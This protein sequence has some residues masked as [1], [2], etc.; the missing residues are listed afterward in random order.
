[1]PLSNPPKSALIV[2]ASGGIG[3]SIAQ[4]LLQDPRVQQVHAT[5]RDAT[6]LASQL[7][8]DQNTG[9][10]LTCHDLDIT[11]AQSIEQV[12]TRLSEQAIE[13]DWIICATGILHDKTGDNP[14]VPE[15]R[16]ADVEPQT[17]MDNF[18]V[19][20]IGPLL[21]AKH[22]SSLLPRT[23][24]A[25]FSALSARVGSIG[26]NRLGGW[27]SYRASKAALNMLV[28]NLSIELVRR[29]RG[30]I[31]TALHP[32]TVDTGLSRPFQAKVAAGKLFDPTRAALQLLDVL[33]GLTAEDN[34]HF[35]AWDGQPVPW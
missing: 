33:D 5:A 24:R 30:L 12:A 15:R 16:L 2:G 8:A 35:F 4:A 31:C 29:H 18:S 22:F 34:G 14:K 17:L 19:N 26:D 1:M 21:V 25:V 3:A 6:T 23:E 9:S 32:G 10:R 27:Y 13:L 28:R 20:S 7:G 11:D